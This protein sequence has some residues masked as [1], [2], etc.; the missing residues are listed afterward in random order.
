M[1]VTRLIAR[2][3]LASM[4][5]VG[6]LNSLRNATEKADAAA[7]AVPEHQRRHRVPGPVAVQPRLTVRRRDRGDLRGHGRTSS[8]TSSAGIGSTRSGPL[9]RTLL[10]RVETG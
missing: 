4:F 1:T 10:T 3:M 6:G 7:R 5:V 9:L 2:P 8:G